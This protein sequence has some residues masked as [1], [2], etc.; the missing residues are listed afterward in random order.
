LIAISAHTVRGFRAANP[1]LATTPIVMCAPGVRAEARAAR[2]DDAGFAL[3]V[4]R[5]SS[6]DRYKGHDA[7]ID[8]WPTVQCRHPNARLLVVGD[9][10]DRPRLEARVASAG[11][12]HAIQFRGRVDQERLAALYRA[13]AFFVMPSTNE[14]FGLV[15]LEAMR[16]GKPCVALHGAADEI[17]QDGV[18]G[19]L[20][21]AGNSVGLT[22]AIVRLFAQPQVRT[23]MG[24]AAAVRIASAFTPDQFARRLHDALGLSTLRRA[25]AA[26]ASQPVAAR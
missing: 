8:I 9:G 18:S 6:A 23:D 2:I 19:I 20:V 4:G 11:L 24:R 21:D 25:R 1:D 13:A 10:D 26:T 5:L 14:G 22:D 12:A 17:I 15:Y 16:A 7:L 3:I